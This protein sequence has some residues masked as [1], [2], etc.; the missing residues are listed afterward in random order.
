MGASEAPGED[1]GSYQLL[2]MPGQSLRPGAK[3]PTLRQSPKGGNHSRSASAM[4]DLSNRGRLWQEMGYADMGTMVLGER[5]VPTLWH[6]RA[7]PINQLHA[8][9][10]RSDEGPSHRWPRWKG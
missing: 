3:L 8:R 7:C 9:L 5:D 1:H 4:G 6:L 10:H 2:R